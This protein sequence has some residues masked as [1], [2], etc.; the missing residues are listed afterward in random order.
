MSD[1]FHEGERAVQAR[2]AVSH[3]A[4]RVA[5]GIHRAIPPAAAEFL[6]SQPFAVVGAHDGAGRVWASP[7]VGP[8]G[9]LRAVDASTLVIA[10]RPAP[11]DPLAARLDGADAP[12]GLLVVEP[13]T[14]RR[15]RVNGTARA[16]PEAGGLEIRVEQVY[17]NCPKYIQK[18]EQVED[19]AAAPGD[20]PGL[21]SP[22]FACE[23]GRWE[24]RAALDAV[25]SG[26][27]RAADT[28]FIAS[29]HPD[30]GADVSHR[31]GNPGFVAVGDD[32]ATLLWP[33]Y[34]GNAMFNTLGNLLADPSAGLLFLDW[35]RGGTLQIT[36]A[37]EI[38]WDG[39]RVS[40][41][42]GAE[43]AVSFRVSE[44]IEAPV[45]TLP[46]RYRLVEYSKFNPA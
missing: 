10:A 38:V 9:F 36:G 34:S 21:S 14:R 37:A 40:R 30:A 22:S 11:G 5:N 1:V 44:V 25:P 15:M 41:F 23:R 29:T 46:V 42:P 24:V 18:R 39:P 43:R 2:A 27:V 7:I 26:L 35:E 3:R 13:Q 17:A 6:L 45:G 12:I 19:N 31:G 20:A 4:S 32:G 28:F 33:D 16:L 8:P